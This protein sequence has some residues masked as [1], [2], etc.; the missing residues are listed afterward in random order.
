MNS[1]QKIFEVLNLIREKSE[2]TTN[3]EDIGIYPSE[4]WDCGLDA[5]DVDSILRLLQDGQWCLDVIHYPQSK[6]S[7]KDKVVPIDI[8]ADSKYHIKITEAFIPTYDR[9]FALTHSDIE[10]L[11]INNLLRV[12]HALYIINE[13]YN[14]SL[15]SSIV[16]NASDS[17]EYFWAMNGSRGVS[18]S[19]VSATF[20]KTLQRLN[21]WG[22]LREYTVESDRNDFVTIVIE[23]AKFNEIS[24]KVFKKAQPLVSRYR[25]EFNE[26]D[27]MENIPSVEQMLLTDAEEKS[28]QNTVITYDSVVSYDDEHGIVSYHGKSSQLFSPTTI[29]GFLFYRSH[30]ADGARV[31]YQGIASDYESKHSELDKDITLKALTNCRK[32]INEKLEEEFGIKDVIGYQRNQFWLNN[33][34]C[35]DESPYKNGN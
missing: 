23:P 17:S 4:F 8:D 12:A 3:K 33:K 6:P 27:G 25:T 26:S 35:S 14:L 24:K 2:L 10:E 1:E 32:R 9:Y 28:V 11:S 7:S 31:E 29:E 13:E 5:E 19:F 21:L 20:R 30:N 34:Y 16:V 15:N 18:L 22:V